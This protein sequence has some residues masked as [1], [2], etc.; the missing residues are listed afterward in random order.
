[1][2]GH[3]LEHEQRRT[4]REREQHD[5]CGHENGE[6]DQDDVDGRLNQTVNDAQADME[7]SEREVQARAGA[8][9]LGG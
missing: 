5:R 6:S 9:R 2:S 7:P 1:V 8:L 3:P 4:H